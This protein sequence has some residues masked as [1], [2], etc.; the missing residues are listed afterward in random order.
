MGPGRPTGRNFD[1]YGDLKVPE[2]LDLNWITPEALAASRKGEG[3]PF[4]PG[5]LPSPEIVAPYA[6]LVPAKQAARLMPQMQD[7]D[8]SNNW[9]VSG[10]LTASGKPILSDDPHRTVSLRHCAGFVQLD[11]PDMHVI[12]GGEPPFVGVDLGNNQNMAWGV[13]FAFMDTTV[14]A[15]QADQPGQSERDQVQRRLGADENHP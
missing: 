8:G 4:E 10:K 11:S 3:D 9:V 15:H 14:C 2:G 6:S 5:K 13:T 1:P 7:P 12:G